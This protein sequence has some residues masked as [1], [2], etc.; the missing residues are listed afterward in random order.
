MFSTGL[1][2]A[3]DRNNFRTAFRI[4]FILGRIDGPDL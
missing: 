4:S 2:A 1:Y 3:A